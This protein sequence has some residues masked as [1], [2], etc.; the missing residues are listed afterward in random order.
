[1]PQVLKSPVV[2]EIVA[3][4]ALNNTGTNKA[5]RKFGRNGVDLT[6]PVNSGISGNATPDPSGISVT[7]ASLPSGGLWS[8]RIDNIRKS[9]SPNSSK[10]NELNAILDRNFSN[11]L[12]AP[13]VSTQVFGDK[14]SDS[15][16]RDI[17]TM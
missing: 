15:S 4:A 13:P 10:S 3:C 6:T 1:M 2:Q 12:I 5:P 14:L 16:S 11:Y 8:S 9:T 17:Y 7:S